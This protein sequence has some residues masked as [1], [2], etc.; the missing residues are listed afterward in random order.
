M[1][2]SIG[3]YYGH[4]KIYFNLYTDILIL[5]YKIYVVYI[6]YTVY[7]NLRIFH[8][9]YTHIHHQGCQVYK[10]WGLMKNLHT[11]ACIFNSTIKLANVYWI[12]LVQNYRIYETWQSTICGTSRRATGPAMTPL[13]R[14]ITI[15]TRRRSGY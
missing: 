15:I 2:N 7:V 9:T 3:Y 10:A 12:Y 8:S 14:A 6:V 11:I 1:Y 5:T 4:Y 13:G